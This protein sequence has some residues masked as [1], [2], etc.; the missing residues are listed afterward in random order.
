MAKTK[1]QWYDVLITWLPQWWFNSIENQE[2]VLYG[3]AAVLERLDSD[4]QDHL[5]ETFICQSVAGYTDE[6]GLER[7]LTRLSG[8]LDPEFCERIRNIVN[9]SNCP[10]LKQLVDALLDVGEC[11][12]IEDWEGGPFFNRET[13][14]NRGSLLVDSIYNAFTIIVDRQVHAPYSFY[15]RENFMNREDFIGT[16]ESSLE[17]FERIVSAVNSAKALGTVY[18]LAERLE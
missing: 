6:H 12:I 13:F 4:L 16:N 2:A 10:A 11:T 1:Q 8:E 15:D 17:L 9:S 7:N 5:R 3:I 18:R 14:F